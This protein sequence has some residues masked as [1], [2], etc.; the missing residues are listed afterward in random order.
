MTEVYTAARLLASSSAALTPDAAVCVEDGV[1][2]YAGPRE[3][4]PAGDSV[5]LGDVT[6]LPGLIDCHVHLYLD[7]AAGAVSLAGEA[8]RDAQR[9]RMIAN[10]R[11]LL[12]AGVT[13]ARDLG[14]PGTLGTEVR[15]LLPTLPEAAPRVL[16]ANAPITVTGGH[17]ESMGGVADGVSELRARV[18]AHAEA[19]VDLIKVMTTGGFM[20]PG[21]H[22][23]EARY[24]TAELTALV[25][26]AHAHGLPVTTHA[27]GVEG[28][29][30]A[31][32]AGVDCIEHCGW[33]TRTGTRFDP[34]LAARLV[35]AGI[36]VSPTMNSACTA[37][38][39]FCPWD[40]RS[41]VLG[42]LRR[43]LDLG[44]TVVAGTDAG[45]PLVDFER[46]ADGLEL[47]AEAGMSPREVLASAT[48][49]AASVCGLSGVTGRLEPGLSADV[50]AVSGNPLEDLTTLRRPRVVLAAG[51]RHIPRAF[52]VSATDDAERA[53]LRRTMTEGAGR[54]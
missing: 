2:T 26:E 11:R 38:E 5:D 35:A 49:V 37:A 6:L 30:R 13:T 28:I 41:A 42:N 18:R 51:R 27:L 4:A 24:T 16:A 19:G 47:L 52:A 32:A 33:V 15:D 1:I 17:A 36:A 31:V 53:R 7:P 21:S 29:D 54:S 20:T 8:E 10:A 48:D 39:Y 25:A 44:A 43:L 3:S 22:P 40:E 12:D 14:A 45:I 9:D 34:A 23:S 46:Y 50:I